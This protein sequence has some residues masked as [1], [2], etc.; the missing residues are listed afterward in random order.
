MSR[1]LKIGAGWRLG[2]DATASEFKGLVGGDDWAIELTED[3]WNDFCRL[4]DQLHEALQQ[5]AQ[6]LMDEERIACEL[7]S[8]RIWLEAEGFPNAY[9]LRLILQTGRRAEGY[10]ENAVELRAA[11][12]TIGTF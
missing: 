7:E 6:E 3:E 11:L 2:W 10:W 12:G 9:S 8:D 4:S 5:I 1:V